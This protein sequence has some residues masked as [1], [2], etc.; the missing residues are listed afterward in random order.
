MGNRKNKY[1]WKIPLVILATC[2]LLY[3]VATPSFAGGRFFDTEIKFFEV[4]KGKGCSGCGKTTSKKEIENINEKLPDIEKLKKQKKEAPRVMLTGFISLNSPYTEGAVEK[5]VSFR[6]KHPGVVVKGV[7]ILPLKGGK[8]LLLKNTNLWKTKIPFRV[9]FSLKEVESYRITSTPTFVF[10]DSNNNAY[11][12]SGQPD[13][14][15]L[16]EKYF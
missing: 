10:E 16:F 14:E 3:L 1:N 8:E 7:A 15:S 2:G 4:E 5:L 6:D 11:K 13:L 9:D 12:I